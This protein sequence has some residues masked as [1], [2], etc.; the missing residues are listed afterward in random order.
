M[1]SGEQAFLLTALADHLHGRKTAVPDAVDQAA[2]CRLAAEQEVEAIL[3]YQLRAPALYASYASALY[4]S[5]RRRTLLSALRREFSDAGIPFLIFKGPEISQYYPEPALRA[6]GDLDILVS[7][8]HKAQA[9]AVLERLGFRT[10][11][12][13]PE[14]TNEWAYRKEAQEV[15]LHH[16]LLYDDHTNEALHI[17]FTDRVWEHISTE[18][19]SFCHLEPEFHFVFLLLHL[20]KHFLWAGVGIRMFTDIAVMMKNAGL[21]RQKVADY[22]SRLSLLPFARICFALIGR[23]FGIAPIIEAAPITEEFYDLATETILSDG[24]FGRRDE[25]DLSRRSVANAVRKQGRLRSTLAFLFPPYSQIRTK[26]PRMG[27]YPI[28][29]PLLWLRR[30][31]DAVLQRKAGTR[32]RYA[33]RH[34]TMPGDELTSREAL[35]KSWGL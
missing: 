31:A 5:A 29:L 32:A 22:L 17:A 3:Y 12:T 28:L 2:L 4:L 7:A 8:A 14:N 19:G 18:D 1:V 6:M 9:G 16:R 25:A 35:L 10:E 13:D 21:D 11:V 20:R 34:W 15:E 26:Y 23:W 27:K 33:V 24:I 30:M